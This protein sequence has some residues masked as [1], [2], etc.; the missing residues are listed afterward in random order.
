[1]KKN[2]VQS[3]V[4]MEYRSPF[5]MPS[6]KTLDNEHEEEFQNDTGPDDDDETDVG[7]VQ[8]DGDVHTG[9]DDVDDPGDGEES[10]DDEEEL[11]DDDGESDDDEESEEEEGDDEDDDDDDA[12]QSKQ[13]YS[14]IA[15]LLIQDGYL[16]DN[17]NFEDTNPDKLYQDIVNKIKD[18]GMISVQQ[19]AIAQGYTEETLR[20]A[21][22]LAQGIDPEI[23]K[24]TT[25]YKI[26]SDADITDDDMAEFLVKQMYTAKKYSDKD[27]ERLLSKVL[28][29][30]TLTE[31]ANE[32]KSFFAEKYTDAIETQK[33]RTK[34]LEDQKQ[35]QYT[36]Y[37]DSVKSIIQDNSIPGLDKQS[38]KDKFFKDLF[39]PTEIYEYE[40]N[41]KKV[42]TK[43]SKYQKAR[44]EFDND[45]TKQLILARKILIGDF[46]D[47]EAFDSGKNE[48]AEELF[49]TLV[50]KQNRKDVHMKKPRRKGNIESSEVFRFNV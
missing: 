43:I 31:A 3:E 20:Y 25:Q 38:D 5:A 23:L 47:R 49:N 41:G 40:D 35:K 29:D 8:N 34:E 12:T 42:R 18:D 6:L 36:E 44:L 11:E 45:L 48:A 37:K 21:N 19:E 22:L 14:G 28:E 4:V 24:D 2:T 32:A 7:E 26:L 33:K 9:G 27:I 13:L 30:N 15:R 46:N 39:D 17:Y 1:M 50:K 16:P 10:E